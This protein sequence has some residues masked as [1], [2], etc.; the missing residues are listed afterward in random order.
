[1]DIKEYITYLLRV[2]LDGAALLSQLALSAGSMAGALWEGEDAG[3][4]M[5]VV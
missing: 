1:M 5:G 2:V 4:R 3:L